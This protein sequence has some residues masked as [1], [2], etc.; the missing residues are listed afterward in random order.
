MEIGL[1]SK[2]E[3]RNLQNSIDEI[4]TLLKNQAKKPLDS[5]IDNLEFLEM[6]KISKRTAQT[7]R[8]EGKISFS[9]VGHKIYY[10]LS[11]VEDLF[12]RHYIKAYH[13][14]SLTR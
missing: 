1:L 6:A 12:M 14:R 11:D 8:D 13:K 3:F 7:W 2:D 9:Q 5:F 10:R 4:K